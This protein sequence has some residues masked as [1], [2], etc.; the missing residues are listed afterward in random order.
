M[1]YK[2]PDGRWIT[3]QDYPTLQAAATGYEKAAARFRTAGV[4]PCLRLIH[5]RDVIAEHK[6]RKGPT[7]YFWIGVLFILVIA[8]SAY[9]LLQ[10]LTAPG[11]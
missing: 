4:R 6:P 11:P 5:G 9:E 8:V 3:W 10:F 2:L 7:I 1:Q